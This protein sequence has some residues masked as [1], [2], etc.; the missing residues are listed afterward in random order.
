MIRT[1]KESS[2]DGKLAVEAGSEN[3]GE[4]LSVSRRGRGGYRFSRR[5]LGVATRTM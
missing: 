5:L 3:R 2:I 1:K 4:N